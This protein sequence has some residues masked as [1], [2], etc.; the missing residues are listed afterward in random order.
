MI[1]LRW[2]A[3]CILSVALLGGCQP[4]HKEPE[5]TAVMPASPEQTAAAKAR[6]SA[7]GDRLVGE[8][9]AAK[10]G[11]AAVSGIDPKAVT[12]GDFLSFIDVGANKVINHG[13][14]SEVGLSGRLLVKYDADGERAPQKGDLCIKLK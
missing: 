11:Y 9:D 6:E 7:K 4:T 8:V 13:T 1:S 2:T 5:T 12:K 14:F 10:D 3:G